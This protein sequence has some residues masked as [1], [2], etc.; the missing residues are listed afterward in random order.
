MMKI[1]NLALTAVMFLCLV[2]VTQADMVVQSKSTVEMPGMGEMTM[3]GLQYVRGDRTYSSSTGKAG[4]P[5]GS[6]TVENVQ[7]VRLD[8]GV[9]WIVEPAQK[10]YTELS[11]A[12]MKKMMESQGQGQG[13][14]PNASD[15]YEWTLTFVDDPGSKT[16]G[17]VKC[18][19]VVGKAVGVKK[20]DNKDSLFVNFEQWVGMPDGGDKFEAFK[21]KYIEVTGMDDNFLS[22]MMKNPMMATYAEQMDKLYKKAL[23]LKGFPMLTKLVIE[24]T[25]N[26]M[27]AVAD[28]EMDEEAKAMMEKMGI[29]MPGAKKSGEHYTV[30]SIAN[31]VLKIEEK[32]VADT[33]YDIPEGF[34]KKEMPGGMG[35]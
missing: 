4:G 16:I 21:E 18:D 2:A 26:P 7:I 8:K 5:M 22:Q 24:N 3:D 28:E 14:V 1:R 27:G 20:K 12:T 9:S 25:E 29:Q 19:G 11:M 23:E 35:M 17:G 10:T 33:Q 13:K 34:T 32:S 31:E 15:E 30:M 6:Q